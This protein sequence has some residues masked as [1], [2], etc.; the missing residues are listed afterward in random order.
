MQMLRLLI[1]FSSFAPTFSLAFATPVHLLRH[2]QLLDVRVDSTMG[3]E[4]PAGGRQ[5][6]FHRA[7]G[8]Q[9]RP[10]RAGPIAAQSGQGRGQA[11][12]SDHRRRGVRGVGQV[13]HE[14]RRHFL[15]RTF[16]SHIIRRRFAFS[17]FQRLDTS[18]LHCVH[19]ESSDRRSCLATWIAYKASSPKRWRASSN[20]AARH[21]QRAAITRAQRRAAARPTP[22][23]AAAR[24]D[25]RGREQTQCGT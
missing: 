6:L 11:I 15:A 17:L 20:L 4:A 7:R 3:Q 12:R 16:Q 2:N 14:C 8:K 19:A 9:V 25:G 18:H 5:E 13:G 23:R 1:V 22:M 10:R 21:P 24:A